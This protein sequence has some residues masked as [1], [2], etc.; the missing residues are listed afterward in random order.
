MENIEFVE[1]F[2]IESRK[3]EAGITEKEVI[4]PSC[5]V[6]VNDILIVIDEF[7]PVLPF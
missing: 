6:D 1:N 3:V 5:L 4:D 2:E 7:N